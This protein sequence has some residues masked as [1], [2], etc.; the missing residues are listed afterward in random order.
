MEAKQKLILD[1][2]KQRDESTSELT[3][4]TYELDAVQQQL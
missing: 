3:K 2:T 4:K 1:L